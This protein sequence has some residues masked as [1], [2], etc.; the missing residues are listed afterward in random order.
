VID[1]R[2]AAGLHAPA[3]FEAGAAVIDHRQAAGLDTGADRERLAIVVERTEAGG[4]DARVD[5]QP[6]LLRLGGH[7]HPLV[8]WRK[9]PLH[10]RDAQAT[11]LIRISGRCPCFF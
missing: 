9:L 7:R 5:P 4:L 3:D 8:W 11:G 1:H 10:T 6:R 2:Q